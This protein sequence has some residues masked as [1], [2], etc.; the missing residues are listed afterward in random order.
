MADG[1][2]LYSLLS[3]KELTGRTGLESCRTLQRLQ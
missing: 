1:V 3:F 2:P